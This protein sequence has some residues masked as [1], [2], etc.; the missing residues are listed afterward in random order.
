MFLGKFL[1]FLYFFHSGSIPWSIIWRIVGKSRC[2]QWIERQEEVPEAG[3]E[4]RS[5]VAGFGLERKEDVRNDA[6]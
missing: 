3:R 2:R 1:R 5:N 6:Q 4:E